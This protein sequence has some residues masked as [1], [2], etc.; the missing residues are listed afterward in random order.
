MVVSG[1]LNADQGVQKFMQRAQ[2]SLALNPLRSVRLQRNPGLEV[3]YANIAKAGAIQATLFRIKDGKQAQS[4]ER[5]KR[6]KALME[7]HGAKVRA[8]QS[9]AS[10][11]FGITA[12]VAYYANFA[13]WGKASK[14]LAADPEWQKFGAEIMGE[15]ASSEFLRSMASSHDL[16][17]PLLVRTSCARALTRP[18]ALR[19]KS[20]PWVCRRS[21]SAHECCRTTRPGSG[22]ADPSETKSSSGRH[23]P[24]DSWPKSA[25]V[26]WL[27]ASLQW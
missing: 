19:Q 27:V 4:L 24:F 13:A 1:P 7:K 26:E 9:F 8:L 5:I 12:T 15:Q 10:D 3:P 16:K 6:S 23:R 22:I 2:A 20:W 18:S 21:S 11:P 17:P 14:A 25:P